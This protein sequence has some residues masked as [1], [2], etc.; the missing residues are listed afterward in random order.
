MQFTWALIAFYVFVTFGAGQ[1]CSA[2]LSRL[3]EGVA[4]ALLVI[5]VRLFI[6][7][8]VVFLLNN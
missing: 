7:R 4:N 5:H 2:K 6:K 1:V 3:A 8:H